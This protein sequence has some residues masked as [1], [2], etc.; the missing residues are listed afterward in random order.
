MPGA[1]AARAE[2]GQ[3]LRTGDS[4]SLPAT[5]RL[6]ASGSPRGAP[7]AAATAARVDEGRSLRTG[8]SEL[9]DSRSHSS[10]GQS[11]R[12]GSGS[13]TDEEAE[14]EMNEDARRAPSQPAA[15]GAGGGRARG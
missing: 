9:D 13:L 1:A 14:R 12:S 11:G 15:A 3:S 6:A 7:G 10:S 2:E 4:D 5:P 8:D